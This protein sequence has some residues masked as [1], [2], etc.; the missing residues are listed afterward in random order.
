MNR[1]DRKA[2]STG[3][4]PTRHPV[5]RK[6]CGHFFAAAKALH[7][8]EKLFLELLAEDDV[9]EDVDGGVEGDELKRVSGC[10]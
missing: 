7:P 3:S 5:G 6:M 10:P 1:G 9:D 8:L 2:A 4:T